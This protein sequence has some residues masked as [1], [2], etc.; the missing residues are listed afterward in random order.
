LE[1]AETE[2][3]QKFREHM[4]RHPNEDRIYEQ[5]ERSSQ[6]EEW[7]PA[8]ASYKTC[9]TTKQKDIFIFQFRSLSFFWRKILL[10]EHD[11]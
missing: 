1:Y 9:K 2:K 8:R 4:S 11:C 6:K 5:K 10:S 7:I 3:L